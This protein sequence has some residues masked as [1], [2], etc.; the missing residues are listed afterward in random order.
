MMINLLAK[1]AGIRCE[2][3][4]SPT[5]LHQIIQICTQH[6]AFADTT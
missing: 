5:K 4:Q 1:P 2:Q 3:V 6:I